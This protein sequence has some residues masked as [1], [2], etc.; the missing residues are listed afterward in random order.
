MQQWK[1]AISV[2]NKFLKITKSYGRKYEGKFLI[3][4]SYENLE[5]LKKAY[6][7]YYSILSEY[8]NTEVIK[9]KLNSIYVRK[10]SRKR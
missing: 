6:D 1:M 2:M 5:Q 4:N 9:N 8:P 3:A 10:I 7:I